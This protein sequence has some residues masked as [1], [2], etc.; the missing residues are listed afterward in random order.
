MRKQGVVWTLVGL[1]VLGGAVLPALAQ[2]GTGEVVQVAAEDGLA[3]VGDYYAPAGEALDA[4]APGVLLLHML[5]SNRAAWAGLI[6]PLQEAGYAVLAVDMRGHG[7][8]G[9]RADWP[10]A[11]AD[12]QTWLDWLRAQEG[13]D[14]ARLSLVGASIGANLALRGMAN[15]P[16]VLTAVALSPG[17]DYRGVT[18]ADA[19]AT[20]DDR[21]VMLVAGQ[22]DTCQRPDAQAAYP[23]LERRHARPAV[24]LTRAW[25]PTA[26]FP[27]GP[28]RRDCRLAGRA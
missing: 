16:D 14:P 24:R 13:V 10:L 12:V 18:T 15:D 27:A 9:G 25:D 20:I 3:L 26:R 21:P 28:G 17:L 23:G 1:L 19:I 7:Q 2:G 4:G 8:T 22:G 11:E 5:N 6:P